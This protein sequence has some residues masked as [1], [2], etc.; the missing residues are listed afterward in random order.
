[1]LISVGGSLEAGVV[2][3][4]L[5]MESLEWGVVAVVPPDAPLPPV[6]M[7]GTSPKGDT[8]SQSALIAV[9][10]LVSSSCCLHIIISCT[11]IFRVS[12]ISHR[13]I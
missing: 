8:H 1:M 2:D 5:H 3:G 7:I 13:L 9:P 12:T 11:K 4:S 10:A 6:P